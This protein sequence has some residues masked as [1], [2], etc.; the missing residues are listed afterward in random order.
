MISFG[1]ERDSKLNGK[2]ISDKLKELNSIDKLQ[3]TD[4]ELNEYLNYGILIEANN[5]YLTRTGKKIQVDLLKSKNY[6]FNLDF[7]NLI[8]QCEELVLKENIKR[9]YC[10]TADTYNK[11]KNNKLIITKSDVEYYRLFENELW[12]VVII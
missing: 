1:L 4:V 5:K 12:R 3:C 7:S 10:M 2:E 11:Y 8:Y 6:K 9:I